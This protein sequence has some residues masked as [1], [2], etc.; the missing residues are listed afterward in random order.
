MNQDAYN[1]ALRRLSAREYSAHELA[2]YLERK[3]ISREDAAEVVAKLVADRLLDDD[4]Y[5]RMMVR[6]QAGR[7]K[8]AG[9]IRMKLKAKGVELSTVQTRALL[10]QVAD[11]SEL[12][13]ARELIERKYPDAS[14]D[15][16]AAAKAIQAL[17]RRG[18][19]Y[20][21]ARKA[22]SGAAPDEDY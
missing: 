5:A 2:A 7:G 11:K 22:L 21:I 16:A 9:Y 18:F 8:G 10:G 19:S 15:R 1:L 20:D 3:E 6:Y 4:R 17:M 12:T 14:K 13:T